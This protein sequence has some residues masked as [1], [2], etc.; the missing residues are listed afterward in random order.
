M[1]SASNPNRMNLLFTR[2]YC[3]DINLLTQ[4][5]IDNLPGEYKT[6]LE[7][8]VCQLAPFN[9]TLDSSQK[10]SLAQCRDKLLNNG[11]QEIVHYLNKILSS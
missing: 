9:S 2:K 11:E 10:Q 6:Q 3:S 1:K 7:L 8:S 5:I 4:N